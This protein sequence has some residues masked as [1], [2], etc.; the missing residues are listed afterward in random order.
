MHVCL[1]VLYACAYRLDNDVHLS[2]HGD[3][4]MAIIGHLSNMHA[5]IMHDRTEESQQFNSD[6]C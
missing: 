4:H 3:T 2:N 1:R 5:Q 6:L